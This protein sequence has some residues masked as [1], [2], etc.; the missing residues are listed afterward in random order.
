MPAQPPKHRFHPGPLTLLCTLL[1]LG[2]APP[3]RAQGIAELYDTARGYD[4]VYLAA[5]A[6]AEAAEFRAEQARALR[7]PSVSATVSAARSRSDTPTLRSNA[8]GPTAGI[9]GRQPLYNPAN[10][11]TVEQADRQLEVSRAELESA[12]QEL[13]VRV[14]QT[15]FDVLAAQDTLD[16]ARAGK[17]SI[18]EQLASARRNFEVGTA[19]ITDTREAQARFDLGTAQEIT[20][21]NDLHIKRLALDQLVGRS[22]VAPHVLAT[23]V[24]LPA[25]EPSLVDPWIALNDSAPLVRRAVLAYEIARLES[26][27]SRAGR[28]PTI[29]LEGSYQKGRTHS[30]GL[31][32]GTF[33][34]DYS[35]PTSQSNLGITL[36]L[37]L[38]AGFSVQNR[39]KETLSLEEQARNTVEAARRGAAQS[40]RQAFFGVQ[41]GRAQVRAL[42]AAESST[43][44][45]LEATQLGYKVGVR[46][47]VDVLNAQTQLYT[48]RRDLARARYDVLVNGLRLRQAA[49]SL[50]PDDLRALSPL[51]KA[52][53]E[54]PSTSV[55]E[56][57]EVA[58]AL[59]VAPA[60]VVVASP[61]PAAA[62]ATVRAPDTPPAA[63]AKT[64]PVG[65][66][67]QD[68]AAAWAAKDT[69]RYLG[70]YAPDFV[71][72]QGAS[73]ADW[74]VKRQAAL[75]KSGPIEVKIEQLVTRALG[76]DS[77]E[78]RFS[79]T[80]RSSNF[81]A[82]SAK[83]IVWRRIDGQWFIVS[84]ASR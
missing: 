60:A 84:E 6:Q 66:R 81:N 43:Q 4:A 58:S 48:T 3:A 16:T 2:T 12:E 50:R 36:R 64:P 24:V 70:Y 17:A 29:D 74:E 71:P 34:F 76:P 46:V 69:D 40:T 19:T 72:S 82:R 8:T 14:A 83:T 53:N 65:Q 67:L 41:S 75:R 21:E 44:L 80:Y 13:I 73:R 11:A 77:V 28:L 18:A 25:V 62:R 63:A 38:F 49:G 5:R 61:L 45:A 30:D 26:R 78:T 32:Q 57:R 20:A 31:S 27:K 22:G 1:A 37:P 56:V 7:R 35:G 9:S 59:P 55:P 23:P 15:Y 47:N 52:R 51:L 79:Q 39:L 33:A 54:V 42:E 10:D 68:W